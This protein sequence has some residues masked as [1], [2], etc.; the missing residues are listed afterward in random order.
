MYMPLMMWDNRFSVG[1]KS[2]DDQHIVLFGYLNDLHDAMLK[3]EGSKMTGPLLKKLADYTRTH[4]AEEEKMMAAASYPRLTEHQA[5]HKELMKHVDA[6]AV[7]F[8]RGEATLNLHLMNFL[9]DWLTT[10]ILKVDHQYGRCL[11]DHGI[12]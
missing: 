3:G 10:H 12:Q 9:R 6:Y 2:I 11:N 8:G 1:V 4:F 7:R 5:K